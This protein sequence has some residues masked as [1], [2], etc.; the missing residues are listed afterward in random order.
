MHH[1]VENIEAMSAS[2]ANNVTQGEEIVQGT[3]RTSSFVREY[4]PGEEQIYNDGL[5]ACSLVDAPEYV[6]HKRRW[7]RDT[8][9]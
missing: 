8:S 9:N 7:P 6:N 1:V 4:F 3:F 2:A 5:Y